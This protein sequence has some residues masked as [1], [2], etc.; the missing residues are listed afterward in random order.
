MFI[1]SESIRSYSVLQGGST[2]REGTMSDG[3]LRCRFDAGQGVSQAHDEQI[4]TVRR[5]DATAMVAHP[6][7]GRIETNCG[8]SP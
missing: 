6:P 3:I 2:Q 4:D 8:W 7:P 1:A 5:G